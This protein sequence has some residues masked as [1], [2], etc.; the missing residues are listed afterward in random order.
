MKRLKPI[1]FRL[2]KTNRIVQIGTND[3]EKQIFEIS[4]NSHGLDFKGYD[5]RILRK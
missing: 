1:N 2:L 4:Q 5:F 3:F